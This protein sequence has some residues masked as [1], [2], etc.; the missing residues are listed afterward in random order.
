MLP[1]SW[2]TSCQDSLVATGIPLCYIC[3]KGTAMKKTTRQ[4]LDDLDHQIQNLRNERAK[5]RASVDAE[6]TNA[7]KAKFVGKWVT[8]GGWSTH[9]EHTYDK[10]AGGHYRIFRIDNLRKFAPGEYRLNRSCD[11][12]LSVSNELSLRSDGILFCMEK[13]DTKCDI[14]DMAHLTVI[15]D[16]E[17][18]K[19]LCKV[20]KNLCSLLSDLTALEQDFTH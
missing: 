18:A 17:M 5:L 15:S 12:R 9:D 2:V 6:D 20:T 14:M 8:L 16:K 11:Y 19:V 10:K 1:A 13:K 4:K 7:L 3:S